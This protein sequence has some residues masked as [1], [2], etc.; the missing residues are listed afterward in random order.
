MKELL[1]W[2]RRYYTVTFIFFTKTNRDDK[3]IDE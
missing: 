1:T 2:Q 3:S